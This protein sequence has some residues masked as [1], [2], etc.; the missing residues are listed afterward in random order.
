MIT[1]ANSPGNSPPSFL[2]DYLTP[3]PNLDFRF[4][5]AFM[6]SCLLGLVFHVVFL[7]LFWRVGVI[8]MA[9]FN[10]LSIV[11]WIA[12][13]WFVKHGHVLAGYFCII[14]E[15]TIHAVL[16]VHF[17]GGDVGFQF[18]LITLSMV[19]FI[20][21]GLRRQ[22]T[23]VALLL[24][25][26]FV[27]LHFY[28][29]WHIP[30]YTLDPR[31]TAALFFG[32]FSGAV[33]VMA[34]TLTYYMG[35]LERTEAALAAEHVKSE[36]LLHNVLPVVI[37]NR[38]KQDTVTIAERFDQVSVLFADVCNFTGLSAECDPIEL[39]DALN[40][41]FN[42]FDTVIEKYGLEKI[43][44][45]G[46]NYMVASGVPVP[47]PDHAQA[48][49]RAVLEMMD[50]PQHC[51]TALAKALQFRAGINCGP[52]VAGVIGHTKFHY[53]VWGDPVNVA[54]RME[55]HGIPGKIQITGDFYELIED[56]FVCERRGRIEVKGKGEMET[57]FLVG[58]R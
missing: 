9:L 29:K 39:L 47:R 44:T 5:R 22:V 56:E 24:A 52:V 32:N 55:S 30:V 2:R 13:L 3:P 53:D 18:F 23:I 46:D 1:I 49:A 35:V 45:I 42:Y 57:W 4:Y 33:L 16:S 20:L 37:A 50:Y 10:V 31:L 40:E 15:V 17:V 41:V 26:L 6:L 28:D 54:A 36:S 27:A 21:P 38:L 7:A 14:V 19:A 48:L 58:V 8:P 12:T 11:L 34:L 43:R 51:P 25:A